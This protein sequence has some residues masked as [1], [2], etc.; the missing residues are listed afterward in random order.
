M[1]H[2]I[3][4]T[5]VSYQ[6]A[7]SRQADADATD[8]VRTPARIPSGNFPIEKFA[9]GMGKF[10]IWLSQMRARPFPSLFEFEHRGYDTSSHLSVSNRKKK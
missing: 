7:L 6:R 1:H 3:C 8:A 9:V 5:L 4:G 10:P 2:R